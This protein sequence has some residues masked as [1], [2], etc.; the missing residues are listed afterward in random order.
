MS[1]QAKTTAE[2][3]VALALS[4]R[5]VR[6]TVTAFNKAGIESVPHA[7]VSGRPRRL[8]SVSSAAIEQVIAESPRDYAIDSDYWS[9]ETLAAVLS[10]SLGIEDLSADTLGR[11][12]RRR[13]LDW[14]RAKR[15]H[16][17][18]G[19]RR[20]TM[21]ARVEG[22]DAQRSLAVSPSKA[23]RDSE[24]SIYAD[25]LLSAD[26]QETYDAVIGNLRSEFSV[27][28][29]IEEMHIQLA[30]VYFLRLAQSQ[31]IEDWDKAEHLDRML[32]NHLTELRAAKKKQETQLTR[33]TH[34]SQADWATELLEKLAAA[35]ASA[36]S[37]ETNGVSA[38]DMS[39]DDISAL[40]DKSYTEWKASKESQ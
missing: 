28:G 21:D 12:M 2:I 23:S 40:I 26:E 4:E 24:S 33:T 14:L 15:E 16:A 36:E 34:Y 8:A 6:N 7:S 11:E 1:R 17:R 10:K 19:V 25:R 35:E 3:G 27:C 30:A 20:A 38:S 13:G 39:S 5:S 37:S 22:Q 31:A 29:G 32:K 9:L 18:S